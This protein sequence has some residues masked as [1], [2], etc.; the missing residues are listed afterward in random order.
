LKK[1]KRKNR[2]F[3]RSRRIKS[4]YEKKNPK[5]SKKK[6]LKKTNCFVQKKIIITQQT[7][8]KTKTLE[9]N[10]KLLVIYHSCFL[11]LR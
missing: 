4:N 9:E 3:A 5:I 2:R 10:A 6:Q 1:R 8:K 11:R 7:N